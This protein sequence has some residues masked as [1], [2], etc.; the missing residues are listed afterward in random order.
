[1]KKLRPV[2]F[3]IVLE[4]GIQLKVYKSNYK[5]IWMKETQKREHRLAIFELLKR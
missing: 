4:I 3:F 2:K 5:I 1:M